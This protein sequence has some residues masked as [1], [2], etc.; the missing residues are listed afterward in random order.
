VALPS[1]PLRADFAAEVATVEVKAD[2]S[3]LAIEPSALKTVFEL[4]LFTRLFEPEIR[5]E[6]KD[7]EVLEVVDSEVKPLILVTRETMLLMLVVLE[8]SSL[9]SALYWL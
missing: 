1:R 5:L 3:R 7:V 9:P 2:V 8:R 4:E 6:R